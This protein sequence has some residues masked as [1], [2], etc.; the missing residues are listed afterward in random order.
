LASR[1][2]A[3]KSSIAVDDRGCHAVS[4]DLHEPDG[5]TRL[6]DLAGDP[7]AVVRGP[8]D[9]VGRQVHRG[10]VETGVISGHEVLLWRSGRPR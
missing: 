2:S 8:A 4:D 6:V 7:G 10:D 1:G 9:D 5:R 3:K